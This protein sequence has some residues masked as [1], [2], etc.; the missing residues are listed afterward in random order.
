MKGLL[1]DGAARNARRA[2][3]RTAVL[4]FLRQEIWSTSDIL[5]SV[6]GLRARQAVHRSLQGLEAQGV[7]RRGTLEHLGHATTLWG[8][9]AHGQGLAFDPER[10]A[11]VSTYFEPSRVSP[12]TVE[13]AVSLQRLRVAAERERWS[14]WTNGDRLGPLHGAK[15]P[16]AIARTP[17]GLKVA[18]ENERTLKTRKRYEAILATYLQALRRGDFDLA[19]W[20]CPTRDFAI[21]LEAIVKQIK[22]IPLAGPRI[23]IDPARHHAR[24]RFASYEDWL[25]VVATSADVGS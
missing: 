14:D 19:V 12:L 9:T 10:E 8:I 23:Q 4:R 3:K 13:H 20:V 17:A 1:L 2:T 6:M 22:A 11:P 25:G 7:V 5:G 15:R 16:D 24:L 21:R 18:I